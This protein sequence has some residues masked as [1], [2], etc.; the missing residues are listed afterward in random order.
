MK[1]TRGFITTAATV[2]ALTAT[3]AAP[4]TAATQGSVGSTSTGTVDISVTIPQ[5]ARISN[6]NDI[7]FGSWSGVGALSGNDSLCV[8]TTTGAYNITAT[9][10]GALNA[11]TLAAGL[12]TVPY[13]VSWADTA[14]AGSG[15]GVTTGTPLVAQTSGAATTNCAGGDTATVF[16]DIAEPDLAAATDGLHTGTLTLVVAPE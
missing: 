3:M 11:F 12:S 2:L 13:T 10:S 4:A 16:V 9:G 6:L 14:G 5:L 7:G 15:T 8:W 1:M